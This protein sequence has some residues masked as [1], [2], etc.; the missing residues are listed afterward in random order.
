M[1]ARSGRARCFTNKRWF[2]ECR[3]VFLERSDGG[4]RGLINCGQPVRMSVPEF[5]E[6]ARVVALRMTGR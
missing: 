6:F 5:V 3:R 2:N 1:L 4:G